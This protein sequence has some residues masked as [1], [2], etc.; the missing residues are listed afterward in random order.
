MML[1]HF[2]PLTQT[3]FVRISKFFF[4]MYLVHTLCSPSPMPLMGKEKKS[5]K[6][7]YIVW[8]WLR[9]QKTSK[10]ASM[11]YLQCGFLNRDHNCR[12]A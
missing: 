8:C 9:A 12:C 11:T 7:S 10:I 3:N 2:F 1:D 6:D 5:Q 4:C